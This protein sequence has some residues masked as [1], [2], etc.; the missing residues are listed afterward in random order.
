MP[1]LCRR[2][3]HLTLQLDVYMIYIKLNMEDTEC[4]RQ[5]GGGKAGIRSS[6][7]QG[8]GNRDSRESVKWQPRVSG[9]GYQQ[10]R[11]QAERGLACQ[12]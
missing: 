9:S 1:I 2:G 8:A 12:V 10:T 11:N 3:F 5:E 7:K 4:E 6:G